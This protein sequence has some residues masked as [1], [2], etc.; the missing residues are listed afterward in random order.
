M[1]VANVHLR[2]HLQ[3]TALTTGV[4]CLVCAADCMRIIIFACL[5]DC[6]HMTQR[7][8]VGRAKNMRGMSC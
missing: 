6:K 2:G 8:L 4:C 3:L 7:Q 1:H 5:V